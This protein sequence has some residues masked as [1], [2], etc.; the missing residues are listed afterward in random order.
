M[1]LARCLPE[2][3]QLLVDDTALEVAL[4]TGFG[5]PRQ[6]NALLEVREGLIHLQH[7]AVRLTPPFPGVAE[8]RLDLDRS[9]EVLDCICGQLDWDQRYAGS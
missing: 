2:V 9:T 7:A 6:C 1:Q 3:S 8:A 5:V 4:G